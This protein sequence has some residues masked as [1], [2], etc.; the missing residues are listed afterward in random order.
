VSFKR[1]RCWIGI[2]NRGSHSR[3]CNARGFGCASRKSKLTATGIA[4]ADARAC[5]NS[6]SHALSHTN[7]DADA[8]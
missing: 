7:S 5:G 3:A 4:I 2:G 6:D 1:Q 8:D